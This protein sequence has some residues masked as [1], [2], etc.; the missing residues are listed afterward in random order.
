MP[1]MKKADSIRTGLTSED[2]KAAFR[3]NL[4]SALGRSERVATRNDLYLALALTVRD[5]VLEHSVESIEAYGGA[6]AR[7]VGYLSAE[8]LPG[9]HLANNLLN[10]GITD[11]TREA[12]DS[13]GYKF[14][15]LIG[16]EEEPGLGNG[17]LGRLASCYMDSLA[18]VEVPAI[19]YG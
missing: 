3:D 19:G 6:N 15:E 1:A 16:Q 9:P 2:I 18:S 14:D 12:L 13:L 17:G 5:R 10:L 8:Y 11:A 7:R 4:R